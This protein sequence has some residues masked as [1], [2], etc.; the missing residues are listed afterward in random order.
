MKHTFYL[1][2]FDIVKDRTRY[3]CAKQLLNYGKRVQK[4][5]FECILNDAQFLELKRKLDQIIDQ[6]TDSLRYYILCKS[7]AENVLVTGIGY[8]TQFEDLIII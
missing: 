5:V 8:Y 2:C 3:R 1:I 6:E 7:C 4:S